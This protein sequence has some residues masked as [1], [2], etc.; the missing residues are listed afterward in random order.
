MIRLVGMIVVYAIMHII[1][2]IHCCMYI[3]HKER[4]MGE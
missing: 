3:D 1:N 2:Q 4:V